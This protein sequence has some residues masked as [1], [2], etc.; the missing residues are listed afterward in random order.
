[1]ASCKFCG[2]SHITMNCIC[3]KC[4]DKIRPIVYAHWFDKDASSCRC[5]NCGMKNNRE[6]LFCPNCGAE[7]KFDTV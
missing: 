4:E 3:S 6:T 5:S 1:M 7:M 2:E